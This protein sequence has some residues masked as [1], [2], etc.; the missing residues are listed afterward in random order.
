MSDISLDLKEY[1]QKKAE[2][3]QVL[4]SDIY[5]RMKSGREIKI[6]RSGDFVSEQQYQKYQNADL[7]AVP[8]ANYENVQ[9]LIKMMEQ[10]KATKTSYENEFFRERFKVFILDNY[11]NGGTILDFHICFT[12]LFTSISKERLLSFQDRNLFY[13]KR[14]LTCATLSVLTAIE[15][16]Y[17]SY[18]F[19][20]KVFH[21]ILEHGEE[22]TKLNELSYL[23][24]QALRSGKQVGEIQEFGSLSFANWKLMCVFFYQV[25]TP[26]NLEYRENDLLDFFDLA[27]FETDKVTGSFRESLHFTIWKSFFERRERVG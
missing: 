6:F 16:K 25:L 4:G 26:E 19:L 9:Q 8:V 1:L 12:E 10:L 20:S 2:G 13:L 24:I 27:S 5:Y 21:D 11:L 23:D 22:L 18:D 3:R 14:S 7:R 17:L 15:E